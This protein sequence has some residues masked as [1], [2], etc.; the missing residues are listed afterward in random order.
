MTAHNAVHTIRESLDSINTKQHTQICE[1]I[2]VDDGSTDSTF[3]LLENYP[4]AVQYQIFRKNPRIGR[5]QALN[6][7]IKE[8]KGDFIAILDADDVE[9]STR[10]EK[11]IEALTNN[12]EIDVVSGQYLKFGNWGESNKPS[13]MPT[14]SLAIRHSMSRFRNPIAHSTCMFRRSWIENL[15]GYSAEFQRCQ[16]LELFLRG[17]KGS[18]YLILDEIFIKYRTSGRIPSFKYYLEN[19]NWRDIV[20]QKHD[21]ISGKRKKY[22]RSEHSSPRVE[23]LLKYLY[24]ICR[25]LLD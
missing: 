16:D 14:D 25:N 11:S 5:P 12:P 18:N 9:L 21:S 24:F 19:E 4:F 10:L 7:G 22:L 8:S 17:F 6:L 1:V 13:K 20:M 3:N 23:R 2:I 15:G